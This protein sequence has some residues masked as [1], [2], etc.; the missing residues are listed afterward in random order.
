VKIVILC[1]E[2]PVFLGPFLCEVVRS[3]PG[4]ISAVVL[5]GG[6]SAGER[7]GSW[8]ERMES[9]R[10]FWLLFEPVGFLWALGRRARFAVLGWRDPASV[11]G[12]ARRH[13]IPVHRVDAH[14]S[15]MVTSLL[16]GLQPDLVLNQSEIL[17]D[18]ETLRVPTV[19]FV[20]RHASLLPAHRGRL[21]SFWA[22]A[23]ERPSH[24]VTIHMVDEGIDTGD[25]LVQWE[26]TQIPAAWPFPKV[27]RRL[28][29]E[30]PAL[31]WKA[32]D[33]LERGDATTPQPSLAQGRPHRFP[34]L[35]EARTY[36]ARLRQR[37]MNRA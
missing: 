19:G 2:E 18:S 17:L 9:L 11:E 25:L 36:R 20:N 28:N 27:L 29:R 34:S 22:H 35:A 30:A 21:G 3:R 8:R 13:G 32:V 23:D 16:R 15:R 24:G 7:R 31:F 26:T 5:A 1:Q 33:L 14:R 10:V 4:R 12:V 6:R 37:R